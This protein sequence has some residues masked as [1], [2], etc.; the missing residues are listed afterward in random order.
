MTAPDDQVTPSGD[1]PGGHRAPPG[2][3]GDQLLSGLEK[4]CTAIWEPVAKVFKPL[5]ADLV[6]GF[7]AAW[8]DQHAEVRK[9]LAEEGIDFD[10]LMAAVRKRMDK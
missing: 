4:L 9:K 6:A 10:E 1:A 8:P 5:V 7:R 2:D 3:V